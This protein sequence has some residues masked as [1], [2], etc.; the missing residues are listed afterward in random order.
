MSDVMKLLQESI[1]Q[2]TPDGYPKYVDVCEEFLSKGMVPPIHSS[3]QIGQFRDV[4][5]EQ[6][7]S[8]MACMMVHFREQILA[9]SGSEKNHTVLMSQW[10]KGLLDNKL[11]SE[12]MA[13]RPDF[14]VKDLGFVLTQEQAMVKLPDSFDRSEE[15]EEQARRL[16]GL[17]RALKAE[18]DLMRGHKAASQRHSTQALATECEFQKSVTDAVNNLWEEHKLFYQC[19]MAKSLAAAETLTQAAHSQLAGRM[20]T[21]RED[22]PTLSFLNLPM[23]GALASFHTKTLA[24]H[25][26]TQLNS[27]PSTSAYVIFPPNQPEA[28]VGKVNKREKEKKIQI[29]R[30]LWFQELQSNSD[31]VVWRATGLFNI[32]PGLFCL[33]LADVQACG[34]ATRR[35][36]TLGGH[37]FLA[38]VSEA[39]SEGAAL[40]SACGPGL[41]LQAAAVPMEMAPGCEQ[42]LAMLPGVWGCWPAG[43]VLQA[44]EVVP[45]DMAPA[46]VVNSLWPCRLGCGPAGLLPKPA[47]V[48]QLELLPPGCE[49]LL[50]LLPLVSG[51]LGAVVGRVG[52]AAAAVPPALGLVAFAAAAFAVDCLALVAAFHLMACLH[53]ACS[54]KL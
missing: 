42:P 52:S 4:G 47:E 48:E 24:A 7:V 19:M 6:E 14:E 49:G 16:T 31:L 36:L 8:I 30:D 22:I 32:E 25:V 2:K 28:R 41:V 33:A 18:Q 50:V 15:A 54:L 1:D 26:A 3:S 13:M 20:L 27:M 53:L 40:A 45:M 17:A 35:R 37:P 46:L 34:P 5:K 12:A 44:V 29:H 11:M 21:S 38:A 43:L 39:G 23:L 51:Q 9:I 10:R